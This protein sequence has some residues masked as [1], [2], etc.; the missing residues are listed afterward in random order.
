[1]T[2]EYTQSLGTGRSPGMIHMMDNSLRLIYLNDNGSV[3]GKVAVPELGLYENL[4]FE[5]LGRV[6]PDQGV[7]RPSLKKVAHYGAYGFWSS[8]GDHKFIM[9]M[10]PTDISN[11]LYDGTSTYSIGCDVS[12]FTASFINQQ[13]KLLNRYHSLVTPNTRLDIFYSIG[14]QEL[15]L[16]QFYID[17][18]TCNY[19]DN[20]IS[21]SARNNI[22][23][24]LKEQYFD[25]DCIFENAT[26]QDN[27]AEI[28]SL[29][30]IEQFFV[31][32]S[33][34]T[35][36]LKFE[37]QMTLL[38]GIK[39]ILLL[40]PQWKIEETLDGTVGIGPYTDSRF[41]QP[42]VYTFYRDKTCFSYQVEY[43]DSDSVSRVCVT[44]K[45]PA[46][47]LYASVP[48]PV[49]WVPPAKRTMYVE[50]ADGTNIAEMQEIATD[51]ALSVS[52]SGRMESFVGIFT[53]HLILGDEVRMVDTKGKKE[54]IG[55]V[56]SVTHHVGRSGFSTEFTVDSGGRKK[57][58][59]LSDYIA[60]VTKQTET[61]GVTIY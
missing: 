38:D 14:G 57:K 52:I 50:V 58:A 32:D 21:I 27:L 16:G 19:P 48:Y 12:Q 54:T 56:T 46:N 11:T 33:T 42:S 37:P 5:A 35:W 2:F 22:G 53:P 47:I 49:W 34:K 9:Y 55:T 59:R 6:S 31:S 29:S 8:D 17:R 20:K 60:Q 51:L 18:A 25:E 15:A 7:S 41:E 39:Q 26:L 44:C 43:D 23:K 61:K 30:E 24:L 45:E 4:T 3:L 28:I 13:Q 36:K 40:L 10:L 1:M